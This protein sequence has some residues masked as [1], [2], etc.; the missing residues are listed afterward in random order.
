[1]RKTKK[2]QCQYIKYRRSHDEITN[3]MSTNITINDVTIAQ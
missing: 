2:S 3:I 1:M